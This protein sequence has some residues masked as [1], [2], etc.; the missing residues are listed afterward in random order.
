MGT[1]AQVF[2]IIVEWLRSDDNFRILASR[3]SRYDFSEVEILAVSESEAHIVAA[4]MVACR[5]GIHPIRTL[6]SL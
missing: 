3:D 6:L 4:Q 2:I 5:D 1:D